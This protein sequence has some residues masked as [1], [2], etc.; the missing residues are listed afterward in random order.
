ML[1]EDKEMREKFHRFFCFL[2]QHPELFGRAAWQDEF[3]TLYCY[4]IVGMNC[5]TMIDDV[6]KSGE[7]NV[8]SLL[9]RV[10][11]TDQ[12]PIIFDVGAN[13]GEYTWAAL[14]MFGESASIYCFEP[15]PGPFGELKARFQAQKNVHLFNFALGREHGTIALY[16]DSAET[17]MVA[18]PESVQFTPFP[19]R[20][21][22]F[23]MTLDDFCQKHRIPRID[24]LKLDVEGCELDILHG[25]S[26]L[27]ASGSIAFI[28]FEFNHPNIC[29][30]VFLR[31]FYQLLGAQYT[32]YRILQDGLNCLPDYLPLLEIFA[33]TN[34][35]AVLSSIRI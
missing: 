1:T 12:I 27:L 24:L 5:G 14:Q 30:R 26:A 17:G 32:F 9:A 15:A 22:T 10:L 28:Q 35:L 16:G 6:Q 13:R 19:S 7:R 4:S 8:F 21:D 23:I 18:H 33:G 20:H 34:L 2:K 29:K 31:D 3:E 25:A 11:S